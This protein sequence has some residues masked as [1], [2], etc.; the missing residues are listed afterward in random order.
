MYVDDDNF[1]S[2]YKA[3]LVND[4]HPSVTPANGH[5]SCQDHPGVSLWVVHLHAGQVT[6]AIIPPNHIDHTGSVADH[7]GIP[8][9]VVHLR[10]WAPPAQHREMR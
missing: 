8:P 6:G 5:V 2:L 10:H 4:R 3:G 7:P 9:A 1:L